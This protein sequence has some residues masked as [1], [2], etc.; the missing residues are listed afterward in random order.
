[1]YLQATDQQRTGL[2]PM[3]T[4]HPKDI[5]DARYLIDSAQQQT[6]EGCDG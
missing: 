6:L 3:L 1:M 2:A 5:E 4:W